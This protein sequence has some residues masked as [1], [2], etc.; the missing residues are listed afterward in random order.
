VPPD[1]NTEFT[2]IVAKHRQKNKRRKG[3]IANV[4]AA[5]NKL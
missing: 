3:I 2:A 1:R 4:G 5:Y